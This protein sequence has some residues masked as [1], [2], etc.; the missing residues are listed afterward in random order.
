[1]ESFKLKSKDLLNPTLQALQD[2]GGS[3]N[4]SEI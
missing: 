1:M 2:L 3:A 4:S